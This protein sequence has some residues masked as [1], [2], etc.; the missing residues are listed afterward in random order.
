MWETTNSVKFLHPVRDLLIRQGNS[1]IVS[2]PF[3]QKARKWMGHPDSI[4]LPDQWHAFTVA[5]ITEY[6]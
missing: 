2:H 5:V 3:P 4:E 6:R 1:D